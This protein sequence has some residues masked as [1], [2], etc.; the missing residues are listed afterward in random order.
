MWPCT[1][2]LRLVPGFTR[3]AKISLVALP[4][5]SRAFLDAGSPHRAFLSFCA[6][7]CFT[8]LW[9][10]RFTETVFQKFISTVFCEKV[11]PTS[12]LKTHQLVLFVLRYICI[13]ACS[14]VLCVFMALFS[15]IYSPTFSVDTIKKKMRCT[16]DQHTLVTLLPLR[17]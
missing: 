16:L 14:C 5:Q 4:T 11:V 10:T 15:F 17:L 12:Y 8:L 6:E 3:R 13:P 9:L 7:V 2:T 1:Y